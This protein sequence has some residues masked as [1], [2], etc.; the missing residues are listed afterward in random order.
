MIIETKYHGSTNIDEE[1]ILQFSNGIPGFHD[2][3]QFALLPLSEESPFFAMQSI[4]TSDLAFIV[5]SPFLFFQSYEFDLN[6][7]TM[8]DLEIEKAEDVEVITILTVKEPFEN[9]TANLRAPLI[10]NRT[11]KKA[12]QIILEN[13]EFQT[14]HLIIREG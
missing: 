5:T 11:N 2:E 10:I 1:Q 9:T 7:N 13:S 3:K 6:P 14:K 4:Q 12:K 8:E